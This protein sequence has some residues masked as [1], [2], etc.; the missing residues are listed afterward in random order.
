MEFR[1]QYMMAMQDQSPDLY[2]RLWNSGS[3]IGSEEWSIR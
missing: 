3:R 2:R 1:Y